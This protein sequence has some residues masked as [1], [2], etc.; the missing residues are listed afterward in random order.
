MLLFV[1]LL[2]VQ[3]VSFGWN[4]LICFEAGWIEIIG[5]ISIEAL[6][7]EGAAAMNSDSDAD[8]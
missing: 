4:E 6:V 1:R 2:H 7:F 5:S 3:T 8:V